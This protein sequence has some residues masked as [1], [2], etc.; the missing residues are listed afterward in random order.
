MGES[1]GAERLQKRIDKYDRAMDRVSF[2]EESIGKSYGP[3]RFRGSTDQETIRGIKLQLANKTFAKLLEQ[4]DMLSDLHGRATAV[5]TEYQA[6]SNRY[7]SSEGKPEDDAAFEE[8]ATKLIKV[9]GEINSVFQPRPK[10]KKEAPTEEET[11]SSLAITKK[12]ERSVALRPARINFSGEHLDHL[13][14]ASRF[15]LDTVPVAKQIDDLRMAVAE[16]RTGRRAMPTV[17]DFARANDTGDT[18]LLEPLVERSLQGMIANL[19][20]LPSGEL[21]ASAGLEN[22][23]AKELNSL[24]SMTTTERRRGNTVTIIDGSMA[25]ADAISK[26]PTVQR[27]LLCS[28]LSV[29][30]KEKLGNP[31]MD[32]CSPD[33]AAMYLS[34]ALY[35]IL[36]EDRL[37]A[38]KTEKRDYFGESPFPDSPVW[39]E[40]FH[41]R[42]T[43]MDMDLEDVFAAI[44]ER[45][46]R[47]S[48]S[49]F[50]QRVIDAM[51]RQNTE[52][53]RS[54]SSDTH[55][56][57]LDF[58]FKRWI[59]YFE[60]QDLLGKL[61]MFFSSNNA[62]ERYAKMVSKRI[63]RSA[64]D[65][66]EDSEEAALYYD[67]KGL[68]HV[69][70]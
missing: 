44:M 35:D 14:W 57:V 68:R 9:E 11:S 3:H 69:R 32:I 54:Q 66:I 25:V 8:V 6:A 47:D 5:E 18:V 38:L 19:I 49:N 31:D 56:N 30:M 53:S 45:D 63:E 22:R 15:S 67:S 61:E 40:Q 64:D 23:L 43:T 39:R 51:A 7:L 26:L 33:D 41:K 70:D 62:T 52:H 65:D 58:T 4:K 28:S 34:H 1:I 24:I 59:S 13:T 21:N 27:E 55:R 10:T 48:R 17:L 37:E 50:A 46:A 36:A 16:I 29:H 42:E 60:Q 2:T 20:V 12:K